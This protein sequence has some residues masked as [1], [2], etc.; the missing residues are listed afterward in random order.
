MTHQHDSHVNFFEIHYVLCY[1]YDRIF[2]VTKTQS[3]TT[4]EH[5]SLST[6]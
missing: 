6:F 5:E 1:P 2:M 3:L 4:Y